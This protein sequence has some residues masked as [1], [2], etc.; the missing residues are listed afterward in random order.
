MN[1]VHRANAG[2]C[3]RR[4]EMSEVKGQ[5]PAVTITAVQDFLTSPEIC[6]KDTNN[7]GF[8]AYCI[9]RDHGEDDNQAMTKCHCEY[10][11]C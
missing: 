6:Y 5:M 2:T 10:H 9:D 4:G 1:F 7:F 11:I 8:E 3:L